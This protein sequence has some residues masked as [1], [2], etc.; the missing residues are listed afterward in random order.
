MF[1]AV[2]TGKEFSGKKVM[3]LDALGMKRYFYTDEKGRSVPLEKDKNGDLRAVPIATD[4][5]DNRDELC[6]VN[7]ADRDGKYR[8]EET[9]AVFV[10]ID[11]KNRIGV[12]Q[13]EHIRSDGA[14]T[15]K[16]AIKRWQLGKFGW[17]PPRF[18][19]TV[20]FDAVQLHDVFDAID[21]LMTPAEKK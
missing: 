19:G 18:S 6:T 9:S 13:Y 11:D 7:Y 10:E 12:H 14:R 15:S 4:L 17:L 2:D 21:M 20:S 16:V 1:N 8:N 5:V 3:V